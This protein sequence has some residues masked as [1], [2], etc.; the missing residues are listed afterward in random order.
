MNKIF[1]KILLGVF[2]IFLFSGTSFA[3]DST[4]IRLQQPTSPTVQNSFNIT[5]VAQDLNNNA[6]SV[7]CYKKGP[8]DG[9]FV[10][11]GSAINLSAGG[12]SDN[13]SVDSS[14]LNSTGT[15]QFYTIASGSNTVM[16]NA[17]SVDF[18]NQAGGPGTPTNYTKTKPDNCTYKINFRSADDS[19]K[20][21]RIDLYR[22]TDTSFNIDANSRVNSLNITS[23]TDGSIINN[24]TPNCDTNYY[25]AIRAFDVYGNGSVVVGDQNVTTTTVTNSVTTAA[26]AQQQGAIP[27]TTSDDIE[28]VEQAGAILGATESAEPSIAPEETNVNANLPNWILTHKKISLLIIVIIGA[29]IFYLFRKPRKKS[30]IRK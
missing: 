9:S 21:I 4:L 23:N 16:S 15:Y 19:G 1:N 29:I 25:Y 20:T 18:N 14:I 10:A 27:V 12:N 22:S 26:P 2:A 17:V 11:F 5:F 3:A 8:G 6:I 28:N 24:I 30:K 7:Q 13:C